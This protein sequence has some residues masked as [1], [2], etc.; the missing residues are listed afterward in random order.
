MSICVVMVNA[1]KVEQGP[2]VCPQLM[3]VLT[4][5]CLFGQLHFSYWITGVSIFQWPEG[6]SSVNGCF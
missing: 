2:R 6:V 3:V 4:Q 5:L 1:H